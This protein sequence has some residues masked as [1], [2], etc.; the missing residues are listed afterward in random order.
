MVFKAWN[1][2]NSKEF[3]PFLFCNQSIYF[4]HFLRVKSYKIP[5]L[6]THN[7]FIIKNCFWGMLLISYCKALFQFQSDLIHRMDNPVGF[8][9]KPMPISELLYVKAMTFAENT[10][11]SNSLFVHKQD[12]C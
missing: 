2:K 10:S 5:V 8:S 11:N 9:A 3:F 4:G 7:F 1:G 12:P 6:M